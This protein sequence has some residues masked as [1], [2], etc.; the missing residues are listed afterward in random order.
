MTF[1]DNNL[2]VIQTLKKSTQQ[3]VEKLE[4]QMNTIK[5]HEDLLRVKERLSSVITTIC[6]THRTDAT[7]LYFVGGLTMI[8]RNMRWNNGKV[9][10]SDIDDSNRLR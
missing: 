3:E 4:H 1:C 5:S 8:E 9:R 2:N 10:Y 6:E 7:L